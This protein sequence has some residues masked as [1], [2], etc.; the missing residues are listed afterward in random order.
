MNA[1]QKRNEEQDKYE[2]V[3]A[4]HFQ[5]MEYH[6]W[7]ADLLV[8]AHEK[9]IAMKD[10]EVWSADAISYRLEKRAR[11]E[12]GENKTP[13][14]DFCERHGYSLDADDT[15]DNLDEKQKVLCFVE[16]CDAHYITMFDVLNTYAKTWYV[17]IDKRGHVM[18]GSLAFDQFGMFGAYCTQSKILR[19]VSADAHD[20]VGTLPIHVDSAIF[21]EL[22]K[23]YNR[24]IL[25]R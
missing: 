4:V 19:V 23:Q 13:I 24:T 22:C 5:M 15:I 6:Q 1:K 16:C 3:V 14:H 11:K 17:T 9:T 18:H 10:N 25:N 8:G 20:V 2:R 7:L 21:G 12:Q